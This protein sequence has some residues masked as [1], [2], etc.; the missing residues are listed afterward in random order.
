M[1]GIETTASESPDNNSN[2]LSAQ[3]WADLLTKLI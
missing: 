2:A 3:L 1:A